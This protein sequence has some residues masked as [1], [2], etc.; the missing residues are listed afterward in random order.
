VLHARFP[1]D[2]FALLSRSGQSLVPLVKVR[3]FGM[4]QLGVDYSVTNGRRFIAFAGL[5]LQVATQPVKWVNP[6][7]NPL[8]RL[9]PKA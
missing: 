2:S 9:I 1:F 7:I 8:P 5:Y 6:V 3:D 4:T